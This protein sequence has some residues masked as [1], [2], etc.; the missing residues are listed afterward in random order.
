MQT[1]ATT[2]FNALITSHDLL[3][4][5]VSVAYTTTGGSKIVLDATANVKTDFMNIFGYDKVTVKT[6]STTEWGNTRLRVA[7]VLDNTGSM[8]S[9]GKM[10]ALKTAAQN[11]L[12]QLKS[13]ATI[14][15]TSTS[16]SFRS[17]RTSI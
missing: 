14:P 3:Q 9:D 5:A 8:A 17:T 6:T 1:S 12:T 13:A 16:R 15:Q 10:D 4:P 2:Y 11:L 7:L